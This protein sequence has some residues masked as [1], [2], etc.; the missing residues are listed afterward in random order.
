MKD[1][2]KNK[3]CSFDEVFKRSLLDAKLSKLSAVI[4]L[5]KHPQWMF[6][7]GV[8]DVG[9][10]EPFTAWIRPDMPW[11]GASAWVFPE[12]LEKEMIKCGCGA[13]FSMNYCENAKDE[14]FIKHLGPLGSQVSGSSWSSKAFSDEGFSMSVNVC[15]IDLR[16]GRFSNLMVGGPRPSFWP[17]PLPMVKRVWLM[18]D[19]PELSPDFAEVAAC[20]ARQMR[21]KLQEIIVEVTDATTEQAEMI[22]GTTGFLSAKTASHF[23]RPEHPMFGAVKLGHDKFSEA[24]TVIGAIRSMYEKD[25]LEG[26]AHLAKSPNLVRQRI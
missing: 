20:Q 9:H 22:L 21:T 5:V 19:P 2:K 4:V 3:K 7:N 18:E 24:E 11:L 1:S 17:E 12:S 25:A 14:A 8:C 15:S 23:A 10:S 6:M 26:S 16:M 13:L